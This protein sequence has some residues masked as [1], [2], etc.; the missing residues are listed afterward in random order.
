MY[1]ILDNIAIRNVHSYDYLEV[2]VEPKLNFDEFIEHRYNQ[3]HFRNN[4]KNLE[5]RGI[6]KSVC[7][8]II[9]QF[10]KGKNRTFKMSFVCQS[11]KYL[12][13]CI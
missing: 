9:F 11:S 12:T 10:K 1:L 8:N 3:I 5:L 4:N 7:S 6:S 2:V 13:T